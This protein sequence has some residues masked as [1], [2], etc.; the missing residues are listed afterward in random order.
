MTIPIYITNQP[1]YAIGWI[2]ADG[3]RIDELRRSADDVVLERYVNGV[4]VI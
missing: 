2:E 1:T 3:T 4:R